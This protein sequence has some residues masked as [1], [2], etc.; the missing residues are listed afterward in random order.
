MDINQAIS[1]LP[2]LRAASPA[3]RASLLSCSVLRRFE[4]GEHMFLDRDEVRHVYFLAKR[5]AALYKIGNKHERKGHIYLRGGS[6][7]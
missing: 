5:I 1:M 3:S 2:V 4:K 7:A 6:N